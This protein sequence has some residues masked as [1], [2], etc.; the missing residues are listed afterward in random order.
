MHDFLVFLS[1]IADAI[2]FA[3]N[4]NLTSIFEASLVI[5]DYDCTISSSA[6]TTYPTLTKG[7]FNVL[8][9]M[10]NRRDLSSRTG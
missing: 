2:T 8:L 4:S 10:S 5:C 3:L 9:Q 7:T 6:T 1:Q